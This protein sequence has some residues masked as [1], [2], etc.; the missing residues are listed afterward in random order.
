M[1]WTLGGRELA[2]H[3]AECRTG[4]RRACAMLNR[5]VAIPRLYR[6]AD[7]EQSQRVSDQ[8]GRYSEDFRVWSPKDQ[9]DIARLPQV[10]GLRIY[11]VDLVLVAS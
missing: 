6:L 10:T 9:T 5:Q 1:L 8:Y 11:V 2:S 7:P 3:Q 4:Y